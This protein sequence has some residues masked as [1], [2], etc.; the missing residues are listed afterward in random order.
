MVNFSYF[1]SSNYKKVEKYIKKLLHNNTLSAK[2]YVSKM[3]FGDKVFNLIL[4]IIDVTFTG[5]V[6]YYAITHFN[7]LSVAIT[8]ALI[9]YYIEWFVRLVKQKDTDNNGST[10]K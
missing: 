6:A 1:F 9:T 4:Y 7:W 2:T 3:C 5:C 8:I 10:D